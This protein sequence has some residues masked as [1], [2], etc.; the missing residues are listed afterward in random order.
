MAQ[1]ITTGHEPELWSDYIRLLTIYQST[2]LAL[3]RTD[4]HT[5]RLPSLHDTTTT[6]WTAGLTSIVAYLQANPPIT[7]RNP[8]SHLAPSQRAST[9]A[10]TTY[11]TTTASRLLALSLYASTENWTTTTRPAYSSALAFP[12][13]W[14]EVTP[15]RRAWLLLAEPLGIDLLDGEDAEAPKPKDEHPELPEIA[16]TM[17]K[18]GISSSLTPEQKARIRLEAVVSETLD[19][20]VDLKGTRKFFLADDGE[21]EGRPSGLDCV[22]F[23][24]LALMICPDVPRP[25]LR[26]TIVSRYPGLQAFVND[27]TSACFGDG[28]PVVEPKEGAFTVARR[29]ADGALRNVPGLGGEWRR[30]RDEGKVADLLLVLGGGLGAVALLAGFLFRGSLPVIG[31]PVQRWERQRIGLRAF[32]AAGAL[33]GGFVPPASGDSMAAEVNA[34][35]YG[36]A[37]GVEVAV[38]PGAA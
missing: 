11:L 5:D 3:H 1:F 9:T 8:D 34:P 15:V 36:K 25:W 38:T 35:G 7:C 13:G 4:T 2:Y 24:Y 10:Y 31:M 18:K 17:A 20:L 21:N 28:L 27:M 6:S 32:G 30:W 26:D 22:A 23:G 19:V 37:D 29:F 16:K 33:F 14:T 12:L